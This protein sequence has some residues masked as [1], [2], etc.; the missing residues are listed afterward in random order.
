MIIGIGGVS[1][2]GKTTLAENLRKAFTKKKKTV[3]IFC[4]DD[5]VKPKASLPIIEGIPDW[6]RPNTIKW[7]TLTSKIEKSTADVIIVEG[8]FTFYPASLRSILDQKIFIEIEKDLFK[9]RKSIDK[10]WD[11][12]PDWYADHVWK[13]YQKY[14]KTKGD[15][16]GYMFL[17][18]SSPINA[19]TLVTQFL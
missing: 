9:E 3:A 15:E 19:D 13:S 5:F 11:D 14:G 8:L 6:E 2:A 1:R 12:E 4:Q 7:D 17:D 10:R 18:G 16:S